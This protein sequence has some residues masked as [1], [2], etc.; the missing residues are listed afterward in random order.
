MNELRQ[1]GDL[2]GLF[3]PICFTSQ[4]I[5]TR[6]IIGA[7]FGESNNYAFVRLRE[8]LYA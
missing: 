7:W 1:R 4:S 8:G 6:V 3:Y 2:Q 5:E